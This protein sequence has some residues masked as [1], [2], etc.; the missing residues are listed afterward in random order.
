LNEQVFQHKT[1][2]KRFAMCGV[3][4]LASYKFH[5]LLRALMRDGY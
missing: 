4:G 2:I 3:K 5:F 1:I